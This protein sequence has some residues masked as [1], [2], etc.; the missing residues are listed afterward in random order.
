MHAPARLIGFSLAACIA[1][2]PALPGAALADDR[3]GRYDQPRGD[4]Y[5]RYPAP[6]R[7]ATGQ[8]RDRQALRGDRYPKFGRGHF[9]AGRADARRDDHRDRHSDV[10][11]EVRHHDRHIA[12]IPHIP[13]VRHHYRHGHRIATLPRT[14]VRIWLGGDPYFYY[15]GAFFRPEFGGYIVVGAPIGARVRHLPRG[16]VSFWLG[17]TR[18]FFVNA[19]YYLYDDFDR[20]YVV[21]EKPADGDDL[22]AAAAQE[23]LFVYPAEGQTEAQREQDRAACED[24]AALESGH[25]AARSNPG[26]PGRADYLRALGACLEGRGY[27]VE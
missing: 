18:Y 26:S 12:P 21:V 16:Y 7:H 9:D 27:T 4:R 14:R 8:R 5:N 13:R 6:D 25:A 11:H 1:L 19:T 23:D 24:W 3:G 22:V 17:P 2:T 10:R 20:E 15:E